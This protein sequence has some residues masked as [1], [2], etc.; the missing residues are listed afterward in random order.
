[1]TLQFVRPPCPASID[2]VI[3]EPRKLIGIIDTKVLVC[4]ALQVIILRNSARQLLLLSGTGLAGSNFLT[5]KQ[6]HR[7]T[8]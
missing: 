6:N 8:G 4:E 2:G 3:H 1:M 5:G 7:V